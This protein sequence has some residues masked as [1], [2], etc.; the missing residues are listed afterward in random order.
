MTD[1]KVKGIV[2]KLVDY[3]DADKLASLF[4]L[5]RGLVT[6]KF[7][8]VRRDKA[9]LKGVAQPFTF[10]EFNLI[11]KSNMRTIISAD[12]IDNFFNLQSNYDKMMCGYIVLDI[13]RSILPVEK[14]EQDIFLLTL[15]ALK[16][17][18]TNNEY[19]A[20]I[21]YILEFLSFSGMKLELPNCNYI[22]FDSLSC[23]FINSRNSTSQELDKKVYATLRA[24]D[25]GE[26]TE[27]N[28]I[29]LK[30]ILRFLHNV[31]YLKFDEDIK[32]FSFI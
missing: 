31:I 7:T 13:V 12:I 21:K 16:D 4:T 32:S 22:Y 3:K 26:S 9:K 25:N 18:E 27:L 29:V 20:T 10:A 14:I 11:N 5:E 15:S 17:I 6:A 19:V 23:E 2:V 30:Q 28:M 8:G 24:I 1:E